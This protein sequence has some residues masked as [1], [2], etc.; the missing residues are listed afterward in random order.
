MIHE[1][2]GHGS[3]C[4]VEQLDGFVFLP[5]IFSVKSSGR[6]RFKSSVRFFCVG[7]ESG[8]LIGPS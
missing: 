7:P 1:F 6:I 3:F 4:Q 8:G 5:V 2:S